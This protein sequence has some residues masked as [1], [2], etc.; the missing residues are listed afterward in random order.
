MSADPVR[1]GSTTSN[2]PQT[3][4]PETW[5]LPVSKLR[6]R[7]RI[8]TEFT[9]QRDSAGRITN[10]SVA[11]TEQISIDDLG[12]M[13]GLS[14]VETEK[15]RQPNAG[16]NQDAVRRL[17]AELGKQKPFA[18]FRVFAIPSIDS[19]SSPFP[20]G[21][22][23][24]TPAERSRFGM[25]SLLT[26]QG[27]DDMRERFII[28]T[29]G[30]DA[31]PYWWDPGEGR[32]LTQDAYAV[33][34]EDA[35]TAKH[36]STGSFSPREYAPELH[37]T[38]WREDSLI[39]TET[40]EPAGRT[41]NPAATKS[42]ISRADFPLKPLLSYLGI[43]EN[44]EWY[45]E[46]SQAMA[47]SF[48]VD[49]TDTGLA[50]PNIPDRRR[51]ARN[52]ERDGVPIA[53]V[54]E[55]I[56]T[57][58]VPESDGAGAIWGDSALDSA[59]MRKKAMVLE[60]LHGFVSERHPEM[61]S[62]SVFNLTNEG[63]NSRAYISNAVKARGRSWSKR[64]SEESIF[65]EPDMQQMVD[66]LNERLGTNYTIDD[67][68][69]DERLK[70]AGMLHSEG[71][72][73]LD[74][75]NLDVESARSRLPRRVTRPSAAQERA[76]ETTLT[77]E[78][79]PTPDTDEERQIL[80]ETLARL[81]QEE[82]DTPRRRIVLKPQERQNEDEDQQEEEQLPAGRF[83]PGPADDMAEFDEYE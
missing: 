62:A 48:G 69:S 78:E 54:N 28:E 38:P 83:R 7:L 16:I 57:G 36:Y 56:R 79:I 8:P 61:T 50:S 21:Y 67:I 47:R 74:G 30:K 3:A 12:R 68:F 19:E 66:R 4:T 26:A 82:R 40:V 39:P 52:W 32:M 80:R 34:G 11:Q 60:A 5:M 10:S 33:L 22:R 55:M 23:P 17:I 72:S 59:L 13:L 27:R 20:S 37:I 9:T 18:A 64:N 71:K 31:F 65:A 70:A 49:P 1:V 42:S 41:N 24:N 35:P 2:N 46:L 6:E 25:W 15:L 43:D 29:F 44:G 14:A 63:R 58:L 45:N 53:V 81:E 73:T 77:D 51:T 75:G 76:P